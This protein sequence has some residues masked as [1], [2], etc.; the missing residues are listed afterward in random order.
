MNARLVKG[1]AG[2]GEAKFLDPVVPLPALDWAWHVDQMKNFTSPYRRVCRVCGIRAPV[3]Q[4][5]ICA[6]C[7]AAEALAYYHRNKGKKQC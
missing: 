7:K 1:R 2:T 5:R 3:A 6:P 4:R